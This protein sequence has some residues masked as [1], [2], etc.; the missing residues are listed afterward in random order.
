MARREVHAPDIVDHAALQRFGQLDEVRHARRRARHAIADD[1]GVLRL[2]QHLRRRRDGAGIALRRHDRRELGDMQALAVGNRV[3]LQ[4]GV[5]REKYRPHRRRR[6]DLV[7]AHRR[8][9]EMLERSRLIV[10]FGEVA[11]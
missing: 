8:L 7:G 1:D 3:L 10:P 11:H 9:G 2:D 4:L 6:R 5:E